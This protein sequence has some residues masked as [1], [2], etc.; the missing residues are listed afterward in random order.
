[1]TPPVGREVT[2]SG[3]LDRRRRLDKRRR[4]FRGLRSLPI[5]NYRGD[6]FFVHFGW[7]VGRSVGRKGTTAIDPAPRIHHGAAVVTASS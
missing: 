4:L 5:K 1:M 6:L 2:R 3:R 7:L